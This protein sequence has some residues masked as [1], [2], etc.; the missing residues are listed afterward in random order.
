[1]IGQLGRD[2]EERQAHAPRPMERRRPAETPTNRAATV[3]EIFLL[4]GTFSLKL[5]NQYAGCF[6]PDLRREQR[7]HASREGLA[8]ASAQERRFPTQILHV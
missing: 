6:R 2:R 1:M 3:R 7:G 5:R 4:S 8:T